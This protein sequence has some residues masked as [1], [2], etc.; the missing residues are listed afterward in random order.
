[1]ASAA[2]FA[3]PMPVRHAESVFSP[4]SVAAE[5]DERRR[6]R[7][8]VSPSPAVSD[9][10]RS[11]TTGRANTKSPAAH[12]TASASVTS[13]AS[14]ARRRASSPSPREQHAATA[15]TDA[16]TSP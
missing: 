10:Y 4:A 11:A 1:M 6:R 12:G 3:R 8:R 14:T 2:R 16:A 9:G 7:T 15:G 5:T 13:T